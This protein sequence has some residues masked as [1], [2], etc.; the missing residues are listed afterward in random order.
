MTPLQA[1]YMEFAF[2]FHF[3]C[4]TEYFL[5]DKFR[6][7]LNLSYFFIGETCLGQFKATKMFDK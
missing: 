3:L 1:A 6:I 7:H 2:F 4:D 5:L